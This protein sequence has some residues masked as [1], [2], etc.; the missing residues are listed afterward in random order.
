MKLAKTLYISE[1][2]NTQNPYG[3]KN[4]SLEVLTALDASA[5]AAFEMGRLQMNYYSIKSNKEQP[6]TSLKDNF[7]GSINV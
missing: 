5:Q 1:T 6:L 4:I 3:L 2:S 7:R